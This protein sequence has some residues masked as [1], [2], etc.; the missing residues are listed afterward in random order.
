MN[1]L[2]KFAHD[3]RRRYDITVAT[4]DSLQQII[5]WAR[6]GGVSAGDL[7]NEIERLDEYH[8]SLAGQAAAG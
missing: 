5:I 4:S 7:K 1:L 6:A 3:N 8:Q 2:K